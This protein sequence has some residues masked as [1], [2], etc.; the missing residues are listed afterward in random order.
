MVTN[1]AFY[2]Q[3]LDADRLV[4]AN[5]HSGLFLQKVC[6]LIGNLL[7][8]L[9][10]PDSLLVTVVRTL[11][12]PG[13][14]VLFPNEFTLRFF[15]VLWIMHRLTVTIGVEFFDADVDTNDP[16]CIWTKNWLKIDVQNHKVFPGR[17]TLYRHIID[18]TNIH[19]LLDLEISKLRQFNVLSND[20]DVIAL[21]DR[22][23]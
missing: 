16:S 15:Q 9:G 14:P 20:A 1:H 12:L 13:E 17:G 10:N 19:R 3:V 22:S 7:M 18:M 21:I 23:V 8:N 4:F 11:L 6:S 5:Q 2:I